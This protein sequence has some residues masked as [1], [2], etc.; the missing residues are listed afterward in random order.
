M[1]ERQ[2]TRLKRVCAAP[3]RVLDAR[4]FSRGRLHQGMPFRPT[5]GVHQNKSGNA[6]GIAS[7]RANPD[8]IEQERNAFFNAM[9]DKHAAD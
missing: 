1:V 8:L 3:G 4:D 5:V 7:A 9:V 6:F 2:S